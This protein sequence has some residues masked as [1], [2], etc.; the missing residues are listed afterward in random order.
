MIPPAATLTRHAWTAFGYFLAA[1]LARWLAVAGGAAVPVW[2]A[3][4]FA[5]AALLAWGWRCWPGVF[6]GSIA[7]ELLHRAL[8]ASPGLT[9]A[10]VTLAATIALAATLQTLVAWKLTNGLMRQSV[11]LAAPAQAIRFLL[12]AGPVA[13]L[14]S[15]SVSVAAQSQLGG[16]APGGQPVAWLDWW[17]ADV[18]G[19]VLAAPLV[20]ALAPVGRS[21]RR[22]LVPQL[23][24][25]LAAAGALIAGA[26][27]WMQ[28]AETA[29]ERT[30]QLDA[31]EEAIESGTSQLPLDVE[32]LR[33]V[34]RLFV[35]S[36]TVSEAEFA[37][38]TE[39]VV[40]QQRVQSVEWAP[41]LRADER[42]AFEADLQRAGL[43]SRGVYAVSETAS[44]TPDSQVA[45]PNDYFPVR[46]VAPAD[47]LQS[48]IGL[49]HGSDSVRRLAMAEAIQTGAARATPPRQFVTT[50]RP[51]VMVFMP[52]LAA[53]VPDGPATTD[54]L[55][56]LR[57]FALMTLDVG[58]LTARLSREA[59]S[60][61]FSYLVTDIASEGES[62]T[63][64]G[65]PVPSGPV[66]RTA[67]DV[68]FAGRTWRVELFGPEPTWSAWGSRQSG[69]LRVA[70][71][72]T[73]LLVAFAALTATG[74]TATVTAEVDQRTAEV[75]TELAARRL[76]EDAARKSERN[77]AVTLNSIGDAVLVT[78]LDRKITGMNPVAERLTGWSAAE[79]CGRPV[80]DVFRI[81]NE[82]T[83]QPASIPVDEVLRT[84]TI[85]NLAN[86]TALISRDGTAISIA[87]S[88]A[89][90]LDT[91]RKLTGVVL[92]FR[93][94][95]RERAAAKALAHS[96]SKYR[97]F[98]ER[99]PYGVFV[100]AGG[101][102]VFANPKVLEIL[103][104][105][106]AAD[107]IG[108]P[109]VDL[110]HPDSR[111]MVR[112]R[113][114]QLLELRQ[115]VPP[116]EYKWLRIDGTAIECET[117]AVP[118]EYRGR[119]AA[120]VMIQDVSA[121]KAA[122]AQ[123][124]RFFEL[125]MDL[126]CIAG[127]DGY[128]KRVNPAFTATLGWSAAE[129]LAKPFLEFV[130]PEDR[131]KTDAE[132]ERLAYGM[133]TLSFENRYR[134]KD[135]T[136]KWL[137]W[138]SQPQ[139]DSGLMFASARDV[140][141]DKAADAVRERL[142]TEL[143]LAK[144]DAEQA[145][146]AKSQFLAAMSH[147]IRTPMN[148][149][150]GMVD[151]LH[152]TSL[153]GYQV[154]MV[155]LIRESAYSLL[156]IIDDILDFSKIEAGKLEL[157]LGPVDVSA[158]VKATCGMLEHMASRK[159]VEFTLFVDPR[160]P[161][162]LRGDATRMRQVLLNLTSNAIKFS[163]GLE[164]QGRVSMR[165]ELLDESADTAIVA[166][167][168]RD[169]G[170]GMSDA[171]VTRLFTPFTQADASTT[172]RYGGSGLGLTIAQHLVQ[173]MGGEITVESEP[174]QGSQ[175]RAR[176]PL[177]RDATAE[178]DREEEESPVHGLRCI[179]VGEPDG[180][181][182]DLAAYL[183][184]AGAEVMRS[185][186]FAAAAEAAGKSEQ[187]IWIVDAG[188]EGPTAKELREAAGAEPG[189]SDRF[190]IIGRG[191]RRHPR[192]EADDVVVIDANAMTRRT[193][194]NS[195]AIAAGRVDRDPTL[196]QHG[197]GESD[198]QPPER[199]QAARTGRLILVAEDNETNQQ[200]ILRQLAV[201][202]VAADLVSNGREAFERWQQGRYALI[203]TDLHMPQMDG[204][205]LARA[206]R[207]GEGGRT[208]TPIIALTANA[209]RGE[210][211]RCR[212]AGMDDY[213][214]KP[215]PLKEL[216]VVLDKW[217][218]APGQT[219]PQDRALAAAVSLSDSPIETSV[220]TAIV[221]DNLVAQRKI[222][223]AFQSSL[224]SIS[225][226]MA[227]AYEAD[228]IGQIANAAHQLKSSARA[229]GALRLGGLCAEL[230]R[231]ARNGD[232][233]TIQQLMPRFKQEV[234]A[235]REHLG[236]RARG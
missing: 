206:V 2:P 115:S 208:R 59:A 204:Y 14:V 187:R 195:V 198:F 85:Q 170:I 67:R 122:E 109:V 225:I 106:S 39:P 197:K 8:E 29:A 81:I 202:G 213:I 3:A 5:L 152:Q 87:D 149:V 18:I 73:A 232:H 126:L 132:V 48:R 228:D 183:R 216:Q 101:Q 47:S 104:A 160:I 88:A 72:L 92:V 192:S 186:D 123:R 113:I 200:V 171:V 136:W 219:N 211:E 172:R 34:E 54:R 98:V 223:A 194:I 131:I 163:S 110:V 36:E 94:V 22:W 179:V 143:G 148:G 116:A 30:R 84:G 24:I 69:M 95:S 173:L 96:E 46:F 25:P 181:A 60:R 188:R 212:A 83:G 227:R 144:R 235:V 130:H 182:D 9:T 23:M 231:A 169:N 13:C 45:P 138:K 33:A 55:S 80:D 133:P 127:T 75:R 118:Y 119:P 180:V 79:A 78:G 215:V 52:V 65:N 26:L 162:A 20:L 196:I 166:F 154:E 49:D 124:D 86:H 141:E 236:R 155:D 16:L 151:V 6:L 89:P 125:T 27:L 203:L 15:A 43:D 129:L 57:G 142:N 128:F 221:G 40:K 229:I 217:L 108:R 159:G 224:A 28:R 68:P 139:P 185:S 207:L 222:L 150:I 147:E 91:D 17:I 51:A 189:S 74:R 156:S 230:E 210:A 107:V 19:T 135:G 218:P 62:A 103:G 140:T 71:S 184:H 10:Q 174:G 1:E 21:G 112:D 64:A 66:L 50:S 220:L 100:N 120:L 4:G 77:L 193:F 70:A 176:I 146:R 167:T 31:M 12:L 205:D 153:R 190:V 82:R 56:R 161:A 226:D 165:A 7:S 178:S 121:R 234:T 105:R 44:A 233:T 102:F 90:I 11:P 111:E 117:T 201:L 134:C 97:H 164:R 41:R 175:F 99:A 137:S 191:Q 58:S 38:F 199:S 37:A 35:A 63:I 177:D 157:D 32:F 145:N 158:V 42:A 93:D 214:S 76:A 209:L 53:A 114:R 168:V 61:G